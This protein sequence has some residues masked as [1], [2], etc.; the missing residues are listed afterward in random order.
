MSCRAENTL[1]HRQGDTFGPRVWRYESPIGTFF[2]FTGC[3]LLCQLRSSET[4]ELID[5]FTM[6]IL[7]QSG[8]TLGHITFASTVAPTWPV[9]DYVCDL[10]ITTPAGDVRHSPKFTITV[11]PS[12]S[13]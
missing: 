8:A 3:S 7:P 5:I 10:R 11:T 4:G 6:V 1:F 13:L 12:V 9:G 2:D